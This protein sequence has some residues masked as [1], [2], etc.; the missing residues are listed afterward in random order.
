MNGAGYAEPKPAYP[1]LRCQARGPARTP[2]PGRA[3]AVAARLPAEA[4]RVGADVGD[5]PPTSARCAQRDA[6]VAHRRAGQ[7]RR[8][9]LA[10][11]LTGGHRGRP[12]RAVRARRDRV[13][14]RVVAGRRAGVEDHL[15][16]ADLLAEVHLE[17]L[18]WSLTGSGRVA[19]AR[20]G[21]HG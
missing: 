19:G 12:G 14:A 1:A 10:G 4:R 15:L 18:A 5:A 13:A 3:S 8:R 7:L 9:E 17:V 6:D 21:V 2:T 11:A 20:V 16:R